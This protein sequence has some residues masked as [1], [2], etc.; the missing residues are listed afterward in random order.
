MRALKPYLVPPS[1]SSARAVVIAAADALAPR[2]TARVGD[3]IWV[4][5]PKKE[6]AA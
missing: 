2:L 5:E 6:R 1:I 3:P 4:S